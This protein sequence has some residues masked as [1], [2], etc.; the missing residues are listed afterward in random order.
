MYVRKREAVVKNKGG[1]KV[2][3]KAGLISARGS[4]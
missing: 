1:G 4:T 3:R 2:R